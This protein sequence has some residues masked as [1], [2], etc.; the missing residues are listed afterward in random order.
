MRQM[1][2]DHE[3]GEITASNGWMISI[4]VERQGGNL[5]QHVFPDKTDIDELS[6][7]RS[8]QQRMIPL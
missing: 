7:R 8:S 3:G 1:S 2:I 6:V 5:G 4:F